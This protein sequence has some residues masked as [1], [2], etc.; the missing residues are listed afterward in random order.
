MLKYILFFTYL[1]TFYAVIVENFTIFFMYIF[2]SFV[3]N[4]TIRLLLVELR[5]MRGHFWFFIVRAKI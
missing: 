3:H 1:Y 5:A 2:F 4:T